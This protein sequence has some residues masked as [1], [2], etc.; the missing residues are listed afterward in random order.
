[1]RRV[2]HNLAYLP[3]DDRLHEKTGLAGLWEHKEAFWM[4]MVAIGTWATAVASLEIQHHPIQKAV[5]AVADAGQAIGDW[6]L[7]DNN[8]LEPYREPRKVM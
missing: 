4:A 5:E 1:M 7:S 2:Q 8:M 6:I 3:E